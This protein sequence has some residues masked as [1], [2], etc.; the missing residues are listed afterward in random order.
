MSNPKLK[1]GDS[2]KICYAKAH[3][4]HRCQVTGL[5]KRLSSSGYYDSR[6]REYVSKAKSTVVYLVQCSCGS[7]LRLIASNLIPMER[8]N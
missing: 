5:E 3:I 2:A 6:Q 7:K 8:A 1:A 4:G